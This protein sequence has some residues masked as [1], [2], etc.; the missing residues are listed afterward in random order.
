MALQTVPPGDLGSSTTQD[1]AV[2]SQSRRCGHQPVAK[3]KSDDPSSQMSQPQGLKMRPIYKRGI[4]GKEV[5][6]GTEP[7]KV[8]GSVSTRETPAPSASFSF[9]SADAQAERLLAF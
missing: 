5:V 9:P 8:Q 2:E 4:P 7:G 3:T 1:L 6:V